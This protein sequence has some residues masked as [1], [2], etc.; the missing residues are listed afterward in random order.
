MLDHFTEADPAGVRADRHPE[1]GG[2]QVDGQNLV[3]SGHPGGINLQPG[4]VN[5]MVI[6]FGHFNYF[7]RKNAFLKK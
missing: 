7:W 2:H 5:V 1:L 4:G 6:I 3:H